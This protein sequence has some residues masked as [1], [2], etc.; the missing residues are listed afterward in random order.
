MNKSFIAISKDVV[1][2]ACEATI[3]RIE[4]K[5]ILLDKEYIEDN[6]KSHR[7]YYFFG[8]KMLETDEQVIQKI[9]GWQFEYPS[10]YAYGSLE[11]AQKLLNLAK[12]SQDVVYVTA[13]DWDY[14]K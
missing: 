2:N 10:I 13:E 14:V 9:D 5:R 4:A 7:K 6:R 11:V 1:I 3:A 8:K 12:R